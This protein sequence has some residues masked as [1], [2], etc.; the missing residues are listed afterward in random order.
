MIAPGAGEKTIDGLRELSGTL[1]ADEIAGP[2][3]DDDL[4][5]AA[6][7]RGDHRPPEMERREDDAAL[8]FK[9][10]RG[11]NDVCGRK[12]RRDLGIGDEPELEPD[13]LEPLGALA[14]V[15]LTLPPSLAGD[16]EHH[17]GSNPPPRVEG[18]VES[19][20]WTEVAEEEG[21]IPTLEAE[22]PFGVITRR[23]GAAELVHRK[24][25]T[26]D[27]SAPCPAGGL[28]QLA[29]GVDHQHVP[30][31]Q[32]TVREPR[33]PPGRFFVADVVTL[34]DDLRAPR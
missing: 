10:V 2:A 25:C 4:G 13:V 8:R 30:A 20:E 3:I 24:L 31:T 22:R 21:H 1:G 16:Q 32:D 19:L 23:D 18:K 5:N 11:Q 12:I 9:P 28:E 17:V 15:R 34:K 6:H 33:F 7:S 26:H 29:L 14:V 27:S